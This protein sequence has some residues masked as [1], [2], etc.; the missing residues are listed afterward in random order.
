MVLFEDAKVVPARCGG[1]GYYI[2]PADPEVWDVPTVRVDC[3]GCPDCR[4]D[5]SGQRIRHAPRCR[6]GDSSRCRW[7]CLAKE[8]C[9]GCE[10]CRPSCGPCPVCGSTNLRRIRSKIWCENNHLLETCCD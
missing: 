3:R 2:V 5:G 9:P 10:A 7:D 6:A 4:C 8:R 1:Q